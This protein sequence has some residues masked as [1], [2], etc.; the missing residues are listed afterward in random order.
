MKRIFSWAV[1]TLALASCKSSDNDEP[2]PVLPK[3]DPAVYRIARVTEANDKDSKPYYEFNIKYDDQLRPTELKEIW[4]RGGDPQELLTTIAYANSKITL[5]I[6]E[7]KIQT[8]LTAPTTDVLNLNA[9]GLV[10]ST[11]QTLH[12]KNLQTG[13]LSIEER[14]ETDYRYEGGRRQ[15]NY[16]STFSD[17][18]KTSWVGDNRTKVEFFRENNVTHYHSFFY[19]QDRSIVCPDVNLVVT[20]GLNSLNER[21]LFGK[22]LGMLSENLLSMYTLTFASDGAKTE[23]K[24]EYKFDKRGRPIEVTAT[25]TATGRGAS[26]GVHTRIYTINYL[27]D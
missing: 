22:E 11:K 20:K 27:K 4:H 1:L 21:M 2:S 8:N 5:T 18:V 9:Q 14:P 24:L 7:H 17:R 26:G 12:F 3:G 10:E 6:N 16:S 25:E 15:V 19:S 13:E 23:T